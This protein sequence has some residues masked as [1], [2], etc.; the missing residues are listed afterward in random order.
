[1]RNLKFLYGSKRWG[2]TLTLNWA[3]ISSLRLDLAGHLLD[4]DDHELGRFEGRE[5]DD[6]VD[7]APIDVVLGRGLLVALDEVGLLG[8]TALEGALAEE[9]LHEGPNVQAD[10]R[11]QR[12]VVWFEDNPLGSTVE[13]FFDVEGQAP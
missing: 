7:D 1:M 8:R 13:A 11:P 3:I 6:D 9:V 12:L 10:L 2:S 4:L 5:T